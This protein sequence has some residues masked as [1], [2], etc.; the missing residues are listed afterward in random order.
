[1]SLRLVL[2][3][4]FKLFASSKAKPAPAFTGSSACRTAMALGHAMAFTDTILRSAVTSFANLNP[5]NSKKKTYH[6]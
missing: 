5:L 6:V 4:I 3:I 1:M 2:K